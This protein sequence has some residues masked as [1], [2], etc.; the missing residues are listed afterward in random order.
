MPVYLSFSA[1]F[2]WDF[3]GSPPPPDPFI[4]PYA[5]SRRQG[6]VRPTWQPSATSSGTAPGR[7]FPTSSARS[8]FSV[9]K[10]CRLG[11]RKILSQSFLILSWMKC[12]AQARPHPPK[13]EYG[14]GVSIPGYWTSSLF[15]CPPFPFS[16]PY[17]PTGV[18]MFVGRRFRSN[19]SSPIWNSRNSNPTLFP[20]QPLISFFR[21]HSVKDS[22]FP[23]PRRC[24]NPV[25]DLTL[26]FNV[27]TVLGFGKPLPYPCPSPPHMHGHCRGGGV[28]ASFHCTSQIQRNESIFFWASASSTVF[29]HFHIFWRLL[30]AK[31]CCSTLP[32]CVFCCCRKS[33][34]LGLDS[35]SHSKRLN[36]CQI[37]IFSPPLRFCCISIMP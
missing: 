27:L 24:R 13:E 12:I 16:P 9:D 2:H 11:N 8:G 1:H 3:E 22:A 23:P 15:C 25:L 17:A 34:D 5:L 10:L 21:D 36:I 6:K 7:L 35:R 28:G 29:A 31:N 37:S 18:M 32:W 14:G 33:L 19:Q 30:A 20:P 26:T 4:G